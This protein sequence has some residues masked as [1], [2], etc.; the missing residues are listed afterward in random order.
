MG[1]K[2]TEYDVVV[3]GSGPN[4]L[5]AAILLQ[6]KGLSVLV[7]EKDATPGGG[8]RTKEILQE[9]FLSDVCSAIH[10]MF[11]SS[12]FFQSLP[13]VQFGLKFIAPSILAA[14]PL[15]NG[16]AVALYQSLEKTAHGLGEDSDVYSSIFSKLKNDWPDIVDDVLAPAHFPKSPF[17]MARFGLKALTSSSTF[18]RKFKTEK[19]KALWAGMAAHSLLPLS[20]SGTSSI[21]LTLLINAHLGG[22][23]IPVGGSRSIADALVKYFIS[24]GGKLETNRN[25][26]SLDE[27]P[28]SRATLLDITPKQFLALNDFKTNP[29]YKKQLQSY[30]Y[31]AGAFKIDWL[32]ECPV[33]FLAEDCR[34][35]GTIHLG[36]NFDE[37]ALSEKA[38]FDGKIHDQPFV[39]LAQQSL[40]DKT[41]TLDGKQILW[42]YCHVP[43]NSNVDCTS[44][45]ENQ[46]ERFAPGF[47]NLIIARHSMN[48][49]QM[50]T[51]NPNYVGGD[52]NGG[53]MNLKQLFFKPFYDSSPYKTPLDGVYL[54][55][56]STPPGG[57]VHGM[58]GYHAAKQVL[59]DIW[60]IKA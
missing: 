32:L 4:G 1:E 45:I 55:S 30:K 59:K 41:R 33:P 16:D 43:N 48:A 60:N 3:V 46:I 25:I 54:C 40:F 57:G 49:Q 31:G 2:S 21:G 42:G 47:K 8:M 14:H 17:K 37:I 50:E 28:K 26:A 22:W 6:Q 39:L 24:L 35:A 51:Y 11:M 12:P 5:A 18:S 19:A 10:P 38:F 36:G 34:N 27:L 29:N 56:S 23:P 9:G 13:L 7:V 52:I 20:H 53:E 44:L 15:E 58:C